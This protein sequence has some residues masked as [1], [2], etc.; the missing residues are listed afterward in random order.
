M[1]EEMNGSPSLDWPFWEG[2]AESHSRQDFGFANLEHRV[3]IKPDTVFQ[4][5]SMGKELA[6]PHEDA[7]FWIWRSS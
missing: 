6:L 3:P 1:N 7:D 2:V 5:G 4:S